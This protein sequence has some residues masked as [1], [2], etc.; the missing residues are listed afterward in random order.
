MFST[1]RIGVQKVIPA[2]QKGNIRTTFEVNTT[3]VVHNMAHVDHVMRKARMTMQSRPSP[4][5]DGA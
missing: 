5:G 4:V 1:A 3:G 2:M